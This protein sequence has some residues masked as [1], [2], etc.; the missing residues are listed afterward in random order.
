MSRALVITS[1]AN[2]DHPVLKIIAEECRKKSIDFILI[3]DQRSPSSFNLPGCN[4]FGPELQKLLPYKIASLL[5]SG[6]YARKNL[7]YLIAFEKGITQL[8]ETDD[9]NIPLES[10]WQEHKQFFTM[11]SIQDGGWIN[12]YRY[13]TDH[14]IWPRGFPLEA[15]VL[16]MIP[17]GSSTST[18]NCPIQQSLADKNPDVDAVYRLT[19][20]LPFYFEK[21]NSIAL[22]KNSWSPFNSQNTTWFPEAFPLLYLPSFCSFRMTDIWRSFVAQRIAW[23]CGWH[24]LFR[25]PSVIQDRNAHDLIR[26]LQEEM[27][28][29]CNN[30]AICKNLEN[31]NLQQ[32]VHSIPSNMLMCYQHLIEMEIFPKEEMKLLEAWLMDMERLSSFNN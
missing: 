18:I 30:S 14:Q 8:I 28:G 25:E 27:P 1:I 13:F 24:I 10:F 5:P 20:E 6:H 31:L 26:D 12:T 17:T 23:E 2:D 4:Y 32:G 16:E 7:G 15:L 19:S 29:I 9:D 22:G 21:K 11:P 3:G